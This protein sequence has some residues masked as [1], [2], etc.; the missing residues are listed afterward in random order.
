LQLIINRPGTE[1]TTLAID[2][3]RL[4]KTLALCVGQGSFKD[5]AAQL[6]SL[7]SQAPKDG[8][9]IIKPFNKIE[10]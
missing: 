6:I 9:Y 1:V 5:N 3:R 4:Q 7:L 10:Q 2:L 8:K